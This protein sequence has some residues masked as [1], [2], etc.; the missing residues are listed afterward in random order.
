MVHILYCKSV[1]NEIY[2]FE[3]PNLKTVLFHDTDIGRCWSTDEV[4]LLLHRRLLQDLVPR[5]IPRDLPALVKY[6]KVIEETAMNMPPSINQTLVL[7]ATGDVIGSYLQA[8]VI[9]IANE[10]YYAGNA[11]YATVAELHEM[12][13]KWKWYLST[14]GSTWSQECDMHKI[15]TKVATLNVS[16]HDSEAA[17]QELYVSAPQPN[18]T[19][20]MGSQTV[21]SETSRIPIPYLDNNAV[22]NSI[23]LPL[24]KRNLFSL[25]DPQSAY[26]LVKYYSLATRCLSGNPSSVLVFNSHFHGWLV[27]KV[28]PHLHDQDRWYPAFGAVMRVVETIKQ[29]SLDVN[30][31]IFAPPMREEHQDAD[32]DANLAGPNVKHTRKLSNYFHIVNN[33]YAISFL[34]G[35][36]FLV[37][38]L[39]CCLCIL[40]CL[41]FQRRKNKNKVHHFLINSDDANL[42]NAIISLF[43]SMKNSMSK[44]SDPSVS[45]RSEQKP[46]GKTASTMDYEELPNANSPYP[47][48]PVDSSDISYSGVS[49]SDDEYSGSPS[50]G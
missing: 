39:M 34:L 47:A 12:L 25:S 38:L 26:I 3:P 9:P 19:N 35:L 6:L 8:I 1:Q 37:L 29:K 48:S 33:P 24:K 7:M 15:P 30:N 14:D 22:P 17:C 50:R 21:M 45:Y 27:T 5:K 42:K 44:S 49:E 13:D 40:C 18:V 20:S 43:C 41:L 32:L 36:L 11:D 23:A 46:I 28:V 4:N 16:L 2:T 10:A 31:P